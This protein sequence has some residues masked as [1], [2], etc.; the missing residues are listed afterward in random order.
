MRA[1][2]VPSAAG[3]LEFTA[4]S[5]PRNFPALQYQLMQ[6]MANLQATTPDGKFIVPCISP[7]NAYRT[8]AGSSHRNRQR[9]IIFWSA[10]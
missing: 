4:S 6:L 7:G 2:F 1:V 3:V 8:D 5:T 9:Q 10:G